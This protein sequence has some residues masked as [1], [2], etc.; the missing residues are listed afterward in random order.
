MAILHKGDN[1]AIIIIIIIIYIFN[2]FQINS[3]WNKEFDN[4]TNT[5]CFNSKF[6]VK[7]Q[8]NCR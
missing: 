5:V 3:R 1:D 8:F 2:K 4:S 7:T 6:A